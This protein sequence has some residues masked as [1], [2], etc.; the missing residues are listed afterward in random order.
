M[1]GADPRTGDCRASMVCLGTLG[2]SSAISLVKRFDA[3]FFTV[4]S[5]RTTH[6]SWYW[7]AGI[8]SVDRC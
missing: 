3:L 2:Y 1:I 8:L 5:P 4:T 7:S 6:P